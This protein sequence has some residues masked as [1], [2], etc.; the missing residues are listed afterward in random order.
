MA[1]I[2]ALIMIAL[3]VA[4]SP[5]ESVNINIWKHRYPFGGYGYPYYGGYGGFGGGYGGISLGGGYGRR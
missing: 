1:L 5:C 2:V 4:I 3:C